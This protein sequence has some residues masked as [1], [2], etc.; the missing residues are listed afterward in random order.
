MTKIK[1]ITALAILKRRREQ[2]I[3]PRVQSLKQT[4]QTRPRWRIDI[5][6]RVS[7]KN[8]FNNTFHEISFLFF[9][10][11]FGGLTII[12]IALR[13]VSILTLSHWSTLVLGGDWYVGPLGLICGEIGG[14]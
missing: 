2:R 7:L 5:Q 6:L 8:T 10:V 3:I 4:S 11:L 14:P 13:G 1:S 9:L 12:Q